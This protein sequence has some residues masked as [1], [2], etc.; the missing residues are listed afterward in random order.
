MKKYISALTIIGTMLCLSGCVDQNIEK[1]TT[2]KS[3]ETEETTEADTEAMTESETAVVQNIVYTKEMKDSVKKLL[4][5]YKSMDVIQ[6]MSSGDVSG[7]KYA[8][9]IYTFSCDIK[10]KAISVEIVNM[11]GDSEE[12]SFYLN[13]VKHDLYYTKIDENSE[14]SLLDDKTMLLD[15]NIADFK[16]TYDLYTYLLNGNELVEGTEGT[17]SDDFYYFEIVNPA[18]EGDISGVAYDSLGNKTMTYILKFDGTNYIPISVIV[19]VDFKV[20]TDTYDCT[21]AVQF[22]NISNN[23]LPVPEVD[24]ET[25]EGDETSESD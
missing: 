15:C 9:T 14:W 6:E 13:D 19:K 17:V 11:N 4:E 8:D 25:E 23:K 16:S 24:E 20:G 10:N 1:I 2:E 5:S 21:S 22:T 7:V 18:K 3:I 12:K